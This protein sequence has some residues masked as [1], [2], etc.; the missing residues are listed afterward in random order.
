MIGSRW[1]V[2]AALMVAVGMLALLAGAGSPRAQVY[3]NGWNIGPDYGAMLNQMMQKEQLLSQQMQQH[4]AVIVQQTMA[5][6]DCAMK[7]RRYLTYGGQMNYPTFAYYY[8]ATRG[9]SPEGISYFNQT[10]LRNNAAEMGALMRLREAEQQSGQA[11]NQWQNG[12]SANQWEAGNLL[13]GNST[14]LNPQTGTSHVLQHMQPGVPS[15]DPNTGQVYQMDNLGNYS[16]LM[17]NG[18]WYPMVPR[19]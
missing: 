15:T 5:N 3:Y 17:P 4:T 10:E 14:Y 18:Y 6:P 2:R 8:A 1:V 7:Y 12:F 19:R 16:V 13:M 9:F 11:L